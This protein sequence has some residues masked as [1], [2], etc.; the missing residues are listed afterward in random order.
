MCLTHV[1]FL[2]WGALKGQGPS[3]CL[4]AGP[5][6]SSLPSASWM[7]LQPGLW[8]SRSSQDALP[9]LLACSPLTH[10]WPG[11]YRTLLPGVGG[12]CRWVEL[13]A[14]GQNPGFA[15]YLVYNPEQT[16]CPLGTSVLICGKGMIGCLPHGRVAGNRW[17][18]TCEMVVMARPHPC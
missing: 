5:A 14:L 16:I 4:R 3:S 8:S 9:F 13:M 6:H 1:V 18:G 10:P 7:H 15:T 12:A 17:P 11:S 2:G